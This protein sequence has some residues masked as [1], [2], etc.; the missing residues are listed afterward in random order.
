MTQK[1]ESL[2]KK[3]VYFSLYAP[4]AREVYLVGSFNNWDPTSLTM[5]MDKKGQWKKTLTLQKGD[6]EYRYIIDGTWFTD[7]KKEK[8]PNPFGDENNVL[9]I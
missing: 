6:Y 5:K 7:P 4:D 9:K 8:C 2:I 1:K 3:R